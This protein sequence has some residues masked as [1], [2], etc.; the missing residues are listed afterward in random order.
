M[1][2]ADFQARVQSLVARKRDKDKNLRQEANRHFG[3]ILAGYYH[4]DRGIE[5]GKGKDRC[6]Q[7]TDGHGRFARWA[8]PQPTPT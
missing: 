4:F 7:R 3:E 1:T 6:T 8:A 5:R 2:E